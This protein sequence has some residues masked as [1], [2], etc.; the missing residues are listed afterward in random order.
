MTN[1]PPK[2]VLEQISTCWP[3]INNPVQFVMRYS[4]AIQ[5]YV[6]AI[7]RHTHDADEVAQEFLVRV[8]EKNFCPENVSRG[9]F[10][11]Y[12]KSAVRFVAISHLRRRQPIGLT[13]E[14]LSRLIEPDST[15]EM[16][17][18]QEWRACVLERVWQALECH[19]QK[20]PDNLFHTILR[21]HTNDPKIS[22]DVMAR[23]LSERLGRTIQP[24]AVR[25]QL[26][27]ARKQFAK[28]IVAEVR[29]TLQPATA[30]VVEQELID[31]DLM[32]YV[33]EFL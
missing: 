8:F 30:D 17:W 1:L 11:D 31:L 32:C 33:Q 27:R 12:L 28:L 7:V 19:E 14:M 23:Q 22:S 16:A 4:R 6:A 10:R 15:A 13:E 9:R 3:T 25:Q 5:K 21:A 29:Q 20:S 26:S 18:A 2:S 24:E